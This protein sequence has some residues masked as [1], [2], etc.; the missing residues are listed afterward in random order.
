MRRVPDGGV[1]SLFERFVPLDL[2]VHCETSWVKHC[3]IAKH[4]LSPL[5][6]SISGI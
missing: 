4:P 5:S 1:H 6:E 3:S 2:H